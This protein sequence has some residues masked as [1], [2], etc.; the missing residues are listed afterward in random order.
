MQNK[1]IAE[2][3]R[4]MEKNYI[5]GSETTISKYVKFDLYENINKI[6]AYLNSKHISGEKDSK[7]REKPFFNIVTSA[8]NIWYRATDIDRKNIQIRATKRKN[9]ISSFLMTLLLQDWMRKYNFGVFL[10]E[11]GRTLSRYGSA[12][13]KHIEK[14][15]ELISEVIPWNR[16]ICDAVDF[17]N[18]PKI[19]KLY[20]T[21]SQLRKNKDYDQDYVEELIDKAGSSRETLGGD[22]KDN[23][24]NFIPVYEIHGEFPLSYLTDNED[25]EDIYIQQMHTLCFIEAKDQDGNKRIDGSGKTVYQNF[26]LYRGKEAQ[27]P[28]Q[29]DH[30]IKEDGRTMSIGAVE[31][32]FEAQWMQNHTVKLIKDQLDLASK[33]V[34]QTSDG[35]LVGRNLLSNIDNGSILVTAPN[36]P[37]TQLNNNS[38]DIT[39]LQNFGTQWN[40]LAD[41][42]N[43]TPEAQRGVTPP[44]GTAWRLQET[45]IQQ[46][47]SLFELMT[48]NKGLG[49]EN[50][51]RKFILPNLKRKMNTTEEISGILTE[52]QIRKID[53][54][55]VPN[56]IIRQVNQKKIDIILSGQ[57][58]D[59]ANEPMDAIKAEQGIRKELD[60]MGSQRF[61]SPSDI[62]T[63][64]WKEVL[65]DVE[66]EIEIDITGEPKDVQTALTTL[67]SVM[68]TIGANPMILQNPDAKVIFN[69]ILELT[70]SLNP[71]ELS[72]TAAPAMAQPVQ[73][74]Q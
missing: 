21:P 57:I 52:Q 55:Y 64:T 14:N 28:Y 36:Q 3:V 7:G 11:W 27:D 59:P 68:Q 56:E 51:L 20:F 42:I 32:L 6:D 67:S 65:K 73:S 15:G 43:N 5:S 12:V 19:E 41:R 70:G 17:E 58:Y 33:L 48:E 35:N 2:I 60:E 53:L 74:A 44:S 22:K 18:N 50:M 9:K 26:T 23:I 13:S 8:C 69:K 24:D 54:M 71:M 40:I 66:D 39:S 4:E 30:L 62:K 63:K 37:I 72:Q 31:N 45:V 29:I 46:S 16:L 10:N 61:I 1:T 34:Y 25:D 47:Q 49:L 38:H